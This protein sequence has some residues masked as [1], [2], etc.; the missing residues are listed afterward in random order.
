MW[1]DRIVP[2]S[3]E[4]VWGNS[5]GGELGIGDFDS[6]LIGGVVDCGA[7]AQTLLSSGCGDEVDDDFMAYQWPTPPIQ[8]DEREQSVFDLIPLARAGREVAHSD[9][10]AE[11]VGQLLKFQFPETDPLAIGSTATGQDHQLSRG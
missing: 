9:C 3:V 5:Y 1:R 11:F 10:Q 8:A 2:V 6:F 7:N 4:G